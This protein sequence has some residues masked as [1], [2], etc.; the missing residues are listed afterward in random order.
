M[1]IYRWLW[2]MARWPLLLLLYLLAWLG[3]SIARLS[4][5]AIIGLRGAPLGVG[6][7]DVRRLYGLPH[8]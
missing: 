7:D 2:R 3:A 6:A 1:E 5:L 8:V 4:T